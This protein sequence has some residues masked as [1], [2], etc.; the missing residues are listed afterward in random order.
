VPA[1]LPADTGAFSGRTGELARLDRLLAAAP[2]GAPLVAV[3]SGPAGVGKTTLAVHWAHR[4]RDRFPDGQLHV[5]LRGWA[6]APPVRPAE[7]L[8]RLLHALGLPPEQVPAGEAEAAGRYRSVLAGRRVLVLLDDAR[9]AEQ[10]RPLLPA[11]PGCLVVVTS[12]DLLAGLAAR[13]GAYRLP[14]RVLG[15]EDSLRLLAAVLGPDRVAAEPAAAA[16]LAELC[17]HLP[18]ALR[19]AAANLDTGRYAGLAEQV[20]SLRTGDRLAAL[21]VDGD[22]RAGVGAALDLSYRALPP[23]ERR[24]FRLVG[25]APVAELTAPAAAALLDGA[26][27]DAR[28]GLDRLAA[29]HLLERRGP[30]RFGCHDL[31]RLYA[32]G[33]EP[34]PPDDGWAGA[35][36]LGAWYLDRVGAA[37][38]LLAPEKLRLPAPEPTAAFADHAEALGWLDAERADLVALAA[39]AARNGPP[40][41]AY[42]LADALRG[43]F[44]LRMHVGDWL[45]VSRAGLG[46]AERA[47]DDRAAAACWLGLADAAMLSGQHE[48]ATERYARA[49][50]LAERAG[51]ESG[52]SAVLGNLGNVYWRRG[53]L[54]EAAEHFE[55][56][57]AIDRR[58]G[59]LAGQAVKLG[60][61]GSVHRA[62]GR[63]A[64]AA[65]H[66][67]RS[68]A[69]ERRTG[70]VSG[71]AVELADLGEVL[72]L[73]G[74][75]RR[76]QRLL[77]EALRLQREVG[78]RASEAE[79]LRLLAAVHADAGSAEAVELAGMAVALARETGER[80]VEADALTVL[81]RALAGSAG[82]RPAYEQALL[83][84]R[85]T[86]A[87]YSE[88]EALLGLA[89]TDRRLGDLDRARSAATGA[90]E[91]SRQRSYGLVEAAALAELAAVELA[92]GRT[93]AAAAHAAEA[94]AG[95][96]RGGHRLG[97]ARALVLLARA[98]RRRDP[99]AAVAA[100]RRA[101]ELAIAVGGLTGGDL[102]DPLVS[103][104]GSAG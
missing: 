102:P 90:L 61:L 29:A 94:A 74:R 5:D 67:R 101:A 96:T 93:D 46:A 92:L 24:L 86:G 41:L 69:L 42:R 25:T 9:D 17:G 95:C 82:A 65:E 77:I 39:H 98:R 57:L 27:P 83:V 48:P 14:V 99:A 43:Y 58:S 88:A 22:S 33:L 11:A 15:A 34:D 20:A 36:R 72:A 76:A 89:A 10:V 97:E 6:P 16:E 18:L 79:T 49:Y 60:N 100:A 85:E 40:E 4:V 30:D 64:E 81:G 70:S 37:V 28:R 12:R 51:W 3:L 71:E 26:V 59:W 1:E 84:S 62:A 103:R 63:L 45:A 56:A 54:A 32:A 53:R 21:E 44:W 35:A 31:L 68:L 75:P 52:R 47:G 13:N 8:A 2:A 73:L 91:L 78:D 66:H 19:V 23:A 104:T 50:E 7:A 87:H 55:R 38:R 80:R